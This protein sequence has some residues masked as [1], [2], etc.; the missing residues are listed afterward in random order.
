VF[1]RR[2]ITRPSDGISESHDTL[3][4]ASFDK[5]RR[6]GAYALH[7]QAHGLSYGIPAAI[8]Q[9]LDNGRTVAVNVSRTIIGEAAQ[10]FPY[11]LV[12][13]VTASADVMAVRL[14]ARGRE[15]ADAAGARMARQTVTFPVGVPLLTIDN[16]GDLRSAGEQF[17][18]ALRNTLSN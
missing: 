4:V 17:I 9:E 10:R 1:P 5:A 16:S 12:I 18:A 11:C 7:W 2:V 14:A 13:H 8:T 15:S 6:N 3:D